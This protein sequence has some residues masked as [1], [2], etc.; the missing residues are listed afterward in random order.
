MKTIVNRILSI[1]LLLLG[2]SFAVI[3]LECQAANN[4]S[5]LDLSTDN[6]S[7]ISD[8]QW[9]GT[10]EDGTILGFRYQYGRIHFCGA[11]SHQ[12]KI[13]LPDSVRISSDTYPVVVIGYYRCDFN[14]AQNVDTLVIPSTITAVDHLPEPL[15]VLQT[16]SYISSVQYEELYK[17]GKV[18]VPIDVL[19]SYY[20]N[21]QW[22]NYVLINPEGTEPLKVTIN[23]SKAGEFAQ[24]VSQMVDH[25]YKVNELT[26]IGDLNTDDLNEFK[27]FRQLTKLDLSGANF[28]DLP[29][30]FGGAGYSETREAFNLLED[31]SLPELNS[32]GK[33]ALASCCRLKNISIPKVSTIGEGAFV[34]C[35]AKHITLPEGTTSIGNSAFQYSSLEDITI[36]S[37]LTEI[38][39]NCFWECKKLTSIDLPPSVT[40]I[41]GSAFNYCSNLKSVSL[42]GVKTI[43][44][45]A[46]AYCEKLSEVTFAEGLT[47]LPSSSFLFCSAL[48]EIDLPASLMIE[49]SPFSECNNVKKVISR[50]VIPPYNYF[51]Y[52]PGYDSSI[53]PFNDTIDVVLYVPE[54]SIEAYK[55][56][57]NWNKFQTILPLEDKI[58][59]AYYYDYAT[60]DNALGFNPDCNISIDWKLLIYSSGFVYRD[61]Y[62][63]GAVDYNGDSTLSMHNYKQTHYLGEG[64]EIGRDYYKSHFSSLISNGPM[65]ADKVQSILQFYRTDLWYFISFPYDV[66][67]SDI[68]HTDGTHFVIRKYSGSNR[69]SHNG[70][71]WVDLSSDSVMHAYEGYIFRCNKQYA[72]FNFPAI[73]NTN[74]NNIFIAGDATIPLNEYLSEFAHSRSWNLIGNPYPC[75]YDTRFMD[76]TAP[77]TVYDKI[78]GRYDAYSPLDD[79]YILPP[80]QAFF[81]QRPIDKSSITFDAAGR[82]K[83]HNVRELPSQ[84]RRR[85]ASKIGRKVYNIFLSG[86]NSEDHTR[87]VFNSESSLTYELDKDASKFMTD[88]NSSIL[89]YTIEDGV[90]YAINERP[91]DNGT[92]RVGFFAPIE[93]EYTLSLKTEQSDN[94]VL[95]DNEKNIETSMSADYIFTATA[96]FNNT[97]FVL[98]LG[99]ETGISSVSKEL[100]EISVNNGVVSANAPFAVYAMDGR[101]V[102]NCDS[103]HTMVLSA[104]VYVINSKDVKR[105]IWVK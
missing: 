36:P 80:S 94:V 23:M 73:N 4:S 33:C 30:Y 20:D 69:A 19:I 71:T 60:I 5:V 92:I 74:K 41:G 58:S 68:T 40:K 37:S 97:R 95:V 100:T 18:L 81:V 65:R 70:D 13:I 24:L 16:S 42:P 57:P 32:I 98:K 35:G 89:L 50:A 17:L 25:W 78:Y 102:G 64:S 6:S 62:S 54:V 83:D 11:I 45:N 26:V 96:G 84:I 66:K 87:F 99:E 14:D 52:D 48:T 12:T 1:A 10:L 7:G 77:I 34:R 27:K 21:K 44:E 39:D 104:G 86:S 75:F 76:F 51:S 46:F 82:Q 28:S 31:V 93:G 55:A 56:A 47:E 29:D 43:G 49:F 63:F 101:L 90:K 3:P 15:K 22:S 79:S 88:N 8:S 85:L 61:K 91:K 9:I 67:I 38:S 105:K 72:E 59:N 2:A 53:I 103:D